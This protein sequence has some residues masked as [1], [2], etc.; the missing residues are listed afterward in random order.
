ME[1]K[2]L[3]IN[4]VPRTIIANSEASLADVLRGQ[5]RPDRYQGRLRPGPVRCLLVSSWTEKWSVPVSPR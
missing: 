1:K 3:N 5:A 2:V 4:G